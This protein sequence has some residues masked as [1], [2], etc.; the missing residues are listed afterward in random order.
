MNNASFRQTTPAQL[1]DMFLHY[2]RVLCNL[3]KEQ[4]NVTFLIRVPQEASLIN[5][6]TIKEKTCLKKYLSFDRTKCF[7]RKRDV[8]YEGRPMQPR[9]KCGSQIM[10]LAIKMYTLTTGSLISHPCFILTTLQAF[11]N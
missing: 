4:E 5:T 10:Q 1:T 2:T 3:C 11:V 6:Q 9:K 8:L 7:T